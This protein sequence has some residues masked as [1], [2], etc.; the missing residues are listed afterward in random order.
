MSPVNKHH[1]FAFIWTIL[2]IV[3]SVISKGTA[4]KLAL[5]DFFG[6]DKVAHLI[7]YCVLA[8]LWVKAF[9]ESHLRHNALISFIICATLGTTLEFV[10][11]YCTD[12]R[13]FEYD[14]MVANLIGTI[15]GLSL[16]KFWH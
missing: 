2:L 3:L 13:S 11:K 12:G 5:I 4:S 15:L 9:T 1:Y 8:W 16:Y 6:I 14:D 10:Q 7:F